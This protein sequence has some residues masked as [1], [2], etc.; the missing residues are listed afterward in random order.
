MTKDYKKWLAKMLISKQLQFITVREKLK[1]SMN[2]KVLHQSDL[3]FLYD[4]SR[5]NKAKQ[6]PG[7]ADNE[8][9]P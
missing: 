2:G 9:N 3:D 1:I 7:F 4:I 5:K 8:I 6:S